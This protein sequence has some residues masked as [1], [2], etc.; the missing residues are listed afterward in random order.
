MTFAAVEYYRI[1]AEFLRLAGGDVWDRV[2]LS[3]WEM[4]QHERRR[5]AEKQQTVRSTA[6]GR[7]AHAQYERTRRSRNKAIVRKVR[8][9]RV[10]RKM[11]SVTAAQVADGCGKF[12]TP[13]CAAKWNRKHSNS[14]R[15]TRLVTIDGKAR[16]LPEWAK[17]IGISVG[18]VYQR[19]RN[20]MSP[21]EA[22]TTRKAGR[23]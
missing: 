6:S 8:C 2:E 18:M 23:R 20:G 9:C 1:E 16:P 10:C 7:R 4:A 11:Y 21:V 22:I 19:I 13:S 14:G 3:A 12:C 15:P 17:R 5:S